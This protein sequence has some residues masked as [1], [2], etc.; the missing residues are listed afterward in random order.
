VVGGRR[1]R[2]VRDGEHDR[3]GTRAPERRR[4][5]R[6]R[7][8]ATATARCRPCDP[9]HT[10]SVAL[11]RAPSPRPKGHGHASRTGSVR[12][13]SRS[14][15]LRQQVFQTPLRHTSCQRGHFSHATPH[16]DARGRRALVVGPETRAV[17]RRPGHA[18]LSLDRTARSNRQ[19]PWPR[20]AARPRARTRIGPHLS[21][22]LYK[23]ESEEFILG[24]GRR[25]AV[26]AR[27]PP[28]CPVA[29]RPLLERPGPTTPPGG[30]RR[31]GGRGPRGRRRLAPR[32][33]RPVTPPSGQ[34]DAAGS[35]DPG[36]IGVGPSGRPLLPD[37]PDRRA[38]E[39][40]GSR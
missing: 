10:R 39:S 3:V 25:S 5:G 30:P 2:E 29:S 36:A 32:S 14:R 40:P 1:S 12:F 4:R 23:I 11:T 17:R 9:A 18:F 22:I 20:N 38:R 33:T 8:V 37:I 31:T 16:A 21:T 35:R 6:E 15:P 19:S 28:L 34:T 27:P 26:R 24:T 13:P 7:T